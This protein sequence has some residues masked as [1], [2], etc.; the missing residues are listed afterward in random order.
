MNRWT[1]VVATA[2]VAA[3]GRAPSDSAT[4]DD[5]SAGISS[6]AAPAGSDVA[7]GGSPGTDSGT[8]SGTSSGTAFGTGSGAEPCNGFFTV[9]LAATNPA[10]GQRVDLMTAG[11]D[12]SGSSGR[13]EPSFAAAEI[14]SFPAAGSFRVAE[15]AMPPEG[16]SVQVTIRFG[17]V[18]VVETTGATH[19]DLCSGRMSFRVD[20]AKIARDRCHVVANVDL[21]NSVAAGPSGPV[22]LPNFKVQY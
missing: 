15:A 7:G 13:I 8:T 17:D 18:R 9:F 12:L 3:C 6:S 19:V 4:R 11:V 22:F 21:G 14:V 5:A 2:L 10:E 1:W 20:A 16:G